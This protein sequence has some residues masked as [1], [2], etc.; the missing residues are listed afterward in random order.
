VLA[1][2][3]RRLNVLWAMLRDNTPYQP[4]PSSA[5][6]CKAGNCRRLQQFTAKQLVVDGDHQYGAFEV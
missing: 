3:R 2:A 5:A 1:L 4:T 6:A